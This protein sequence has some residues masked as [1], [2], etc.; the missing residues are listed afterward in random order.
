[1]RYLV[2]LSTLLLSPV[3]YA[4][5]LGSVDEY[6]TSKTL[7]SSHTVTTQVV[8]KLIEREEESKNR[9]INKESEVVQF[10]TKDDV[11]FYDKSTQSL[12]LNYATN[13]HKLDEN[14]KQVLKQYLSLVS[15]KSK[16]YIEGHADS[17]GSDSYNKELSSRR[18]NKVANYLKK[19]LKQGNRIVEYAYGES[20]P[21]CPVADNKETGCN[22][23]VVITVK[24]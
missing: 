7:V 16:I 23:R 3:G 17:L 20:E 12:V 15:G 19:D 9:I 8:G 4:N 1:M 13:I 10:Q 6:V 5:C 2:I 11:C 14:H 22:R 21:I 18:A 24:S